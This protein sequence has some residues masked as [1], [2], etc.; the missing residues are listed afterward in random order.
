MKGDPCAAEHV[1]G[2]RW[3]NG[4]H[5]CL[6]SIHPRPAECIFW[7]SMSIYGLAVAVYTGPKD[8][9]CRWQ[10]E[11]S[12]SRFCTFCLKCSLVGYHSEVLLSWMSICRAVVSCA[13]GSEAYLARRSVWAWT[14]WEIH[15]KRFAQSAG[16]GCSWPLTQ[17]SI[18]KNG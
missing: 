6:S 15:W 12:G 11:F 10:W 3:K 14:V 17:N 9:R 1:P 7:I 18:L 2:H 16:P 8:P 4:D 13:T 5:A